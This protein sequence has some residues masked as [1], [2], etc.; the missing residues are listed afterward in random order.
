MADAVLTTAI[1]WRAAVL[2]LA[3]SYVC[4][5]VLTFATADRL[6]SVYVFRSGTAAKAPRG[7]SGNASVVE[8]PKDLVLSVTCRCERFLLGSEDALVFILDVATSPSSS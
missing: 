4:M 2:R 1:F 3:M 8:S 6:R 7:T 5:N